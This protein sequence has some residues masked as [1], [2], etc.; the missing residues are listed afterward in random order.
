MHTF[1][2][3]SEG[4][5]RSGWRAL[6]FLFF[7]VLVAATLG[8]LSTALMFSV[9][10]SATSAP[11]TYFLINGL[12]SLI[13]A[14]IIGW[15]CGRFLEQ[16]PFDELGISFRG[17]WVLN[18]AAGSVAGIATLSMAVLIAFVFGGLRFEVNTV[19]VAE[20]ALGLLGS[21]VVLAVG[22]AFE[23][24]L[25]RGYLLQT[26][27]RSNLAW[28]AIL[29][30]SLFFGLVHSG[31]PNA[32]IF[33]VSNTILAGVWFS[34]AY[35]RTKELW[36]VTGLHLMWNWT[37]GSVFGIEISGLTEITPVSILREVDAGPTWLTGQTYGIEGGI[38]C[39]IALLISIGAIY[40]W[41]RTSDLSDLDLK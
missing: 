8:L 31:N 22:A 34:V 20:I 1:L 28:L 21:L 33:S 15:L 35:L 30:T 9:G 3:N 5:L 17:R 38:A 2:F 24:V 19:P 36:F 29:I 40:L 26:F 27:M 12:A 4:I 18:L 6:I 13:P 14:V 23:E 39:T 25:F 11:R 41:P 16:L 32:T 10:V 7:F 37:Q